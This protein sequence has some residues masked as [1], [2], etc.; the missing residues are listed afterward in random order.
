[1]DFFGRLSPRERNVARLNG[2]I[3]LAFALFVM[4]HPA[5]SKW[6]FARLI[7]E[8]ML[9]T[10][11]LAAVALFCFAALHIRRGGMIAALS[12][13]WRADRLVTLFW[14]LLLFAIVMP[15]FSAFKQRILPRAGFG[16]DPTLAVIDRKMFGV[17]PGLWLHQAIGSP[18]LTYFLDA[19]YHSWFVPM[20]IGVG[21]VALC[22]DART[23]MQYM[24]AYTM[25]WIGLGS[26]LAYL[27]P[28][29]GPCYYEMLVGERGNAPFAAVNA[30]LLADQA[31]KSANFLFTLEIKTMLLNRFDDPNLSIGGGISAIPSIHNAMAV[32]FALVGYRFNRTFG[33]LMSAFA[34]L[35]WI[36]S[37]YLNWHY[38]IDGIVGAV[39]AIGLWYGAGRLVGR[40][41][42]KENNPVGSILMPAPSPSYAP[43]P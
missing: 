26:I 6:Q 3:V 31:A 28:A 17:D 1:M 9:L 15:T 16:F 13:R 25:T 38:A 37:I 24:T 39:G 4:A 27:L 7:A 20:T 34:S 42:A 10:L 40:T 43:E 19:I 22:T 8:Y 21:I 30:A 41:N 23:R 18:T 12:D 35:I 2:L 14:P 33:V 29:A 5:I 32:L 36:G 11:A